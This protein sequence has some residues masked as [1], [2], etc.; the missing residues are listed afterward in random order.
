MLPKHF[1][2]LHVKNCSTV[3]TG[4]AGEVNGDRKSDLNGYETREVLDTSK[5]FQN[6]GSACSN[7][8]V[9]LTE[10]TPEVK[11]GSLQDNSAETQR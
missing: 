4:G 9:L 1:C 10:Q 3:C 7:P 5:S 8:G 6:E 11:L 2:T